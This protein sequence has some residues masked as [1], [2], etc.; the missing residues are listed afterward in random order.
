MVNGIIKGLQKFVEILLVK[1]NLV[2]FVG[3]AFIV[4]VL[5]L[6]AFGNGE[7]VIIGAGRFYIKKVGSFSRFYFLREDLIPAIRLVFFHRL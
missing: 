2:F 3:K 5:P 4:F 1:E 7:V 6:F